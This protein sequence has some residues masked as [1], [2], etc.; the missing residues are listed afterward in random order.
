[1][2]GTDEYKNLCPLCNDAHRL[3]HAKD[4]D[5][6]NKYIHIIQNKEQLN[7]LN[8]LRKECGLEKVEM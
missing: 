1:M 5:T 7:R 8:A 2:G 6:I 4:I 3:V